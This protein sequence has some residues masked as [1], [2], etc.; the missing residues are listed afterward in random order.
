M[1]TI[2]SFLD[3]IGRRNLA[4][5]LSE[6]AESGGLPAFECGRDGGSFRTIMAAI[7]P[8]WE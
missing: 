7:H 8:A 3:E 4:A 6:I 1:F 2:K 5:E